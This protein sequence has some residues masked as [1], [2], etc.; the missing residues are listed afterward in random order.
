MRASAYRSVVALGA[1]AAGAAAVV[2]WTLGSTG[3]AT[4][5]GEATVASGG[6]SGSQRGEQ[7]EG[8][9]PVD[10]APERAS[11]AGRSAARL[12][13]ADGEAFRAAAAWRETAAGYR[14]EA[15]SVLESREDPKQTDLQR[16]LRQAELL[17]LAGKADAAVLAI[18]AGHY[19]ILSSGESPR[20]L[21]LGVQQLMSGPYRTN[22]DTVCELSIAVHVARDLAA[23]IE[24]RDQLQVAVDEEYIGNWNNLDYQNR[25]E[26]LEAHRSARSQIGAIRR[27]RSLSEAEKSRRIDALQAALIPDRFAV[28]EGMVMHLRGESGR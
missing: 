19:E 20:D 10:G 27:D 4:P 6:R 12:L 15:M 3:A 2:W 9:R 24:Q 28:D 17:L 11:A 25:V 16:L 21:P 14:Q 23:L 18:E 8:S 1:M 26:R 5:G 13:L 7:H 22:R